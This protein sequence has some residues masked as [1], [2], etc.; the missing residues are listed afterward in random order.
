VQLFISHSSRDRE[1]EVV[2]KRVEA[3]GFKA[4]LAEHD[5][6][7]GR[8]LNNKIQEEIDS[9]DA[10]VVVLTRN[11]AE[12]TIVRDEI[13]YSLGKG[14]LVVALVTSDVARDPAKLGMLNGWSTSPST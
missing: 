2:Q 1:W 10:V 9:S 3:A 11:A 12:S 13:G 7:P 5:L 14:K 6:Q 4:Y 8:P